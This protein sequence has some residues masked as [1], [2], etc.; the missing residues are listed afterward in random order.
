[1]IREHKALVIAILLLAIVIAL[2]PLLHKETY[3]VINNDTAA[4]LVVFEAMKS[5]TV[6]YLYLGQMLTGW[7][8][9][10]M[11]R[12]FGTD[13]STSFMWFNFIALF[14]SGMTVAT[15]TVIITR[16]KLVGA[17]SAF[18]VTL[19]IG[20]TMQLFYSGTIFNIIEVLIIFPVLLTTVWL[21]LRKQNIKW[22][23]LIIPTA[24]LL[25]FFHPSLGSGI[26]LLFQDIPNPE[27]IANPIV[28]L[29]LFFGASNIGLF[30]ISLVLL[31]KNNN[32]MKVEK[33][34]KAIIGFLFMLFTLLAILAF[35]GT[36]PFSARML[37][38]ACLLLGLLLFVILG[39][40]LKQDNS[41]LAKGLTISLA[42]ASVIP[43]L[44]IWLSFP[45]YKEILSG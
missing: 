9:V 2:P 33:E 26:K 37:F 12:I 45:N 29:L 27:V 30:V 31:Y 39:L 42:L 40:A 28:S 43:N 35:T 1:M 5:G 11:E 22:L 8:M 32:K 19:G 17:L 23:F 20:A 36:T 18:I 41:L 44:A 21:M 4:H 24:T 38:N 6:S 14:L 16:S 10:G 25:F 15:M 13:I 34:T 3:L 7:F